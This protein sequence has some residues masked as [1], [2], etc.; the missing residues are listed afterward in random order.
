MEFFGVEDNEVSSLIEPYSHLHDSNY[1]YQPKSEDSV[2]SKGVPTWVRS[3][4]YEEYLKKT[5]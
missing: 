3:E 5:K 4:Y 1:F 2:D